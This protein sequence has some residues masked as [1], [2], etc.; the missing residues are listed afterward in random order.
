MSGSPALE[1]V[2]AVVGEGVGEGCRDWPYATG[3]KGY[4]QIVH[5]GKTRQVGHVVL[6]LA[7]RPRPPAPGNQQV[8]SCDRPVCAAPW[9][10]RWGTNLENRLESVDRD[11]HAR[12]ERA[13]LAKLTDEAVREIR[14]GVLRDIDYAAK[15]GVG[16]PTIHKARTGQ[17]WR[18]VQ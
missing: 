12:G 5:E 8:H 13:P 6:E 9:H 4:G 3:L 10:L 15:F 11:R 14:T 16:Q 2:E 18:H 17:T 1:W 7:G